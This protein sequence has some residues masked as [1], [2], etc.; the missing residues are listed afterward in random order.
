MALQSVV[1]VGKEAT[2]SGDPVRWRQV[3]PRVLEVPARSGVVKKL[4]AMVPDVVVLSANLKGRRQLTQELKQWGKAPVVWVMEKHPAHLMAEARELKVDNIIHPQACTE[5]LRWALELAQ[6]HFEEVG[7]A[8]RQAREA[9]EELEGRK[10][11]ERAKAVLME[12]W[13]ISD[14]DAYRRL[15]RQAMDSRRSLKAV[16]EAVLKAGGMSV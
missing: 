1:L 3:A 13:G 11:V 12:T 7:R 16:A 4:Q 2:S 5:N 9:R 15:Q 14:E 8:R 6:E 10:L